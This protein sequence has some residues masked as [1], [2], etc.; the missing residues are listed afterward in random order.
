MRLDADVPR[1]NLKVQ[2]NFRIP[3]VIFVVR[4]SCYSDSRIPTNKHDFT[5]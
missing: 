1:Q 3:K 4:W 2:K 5:A